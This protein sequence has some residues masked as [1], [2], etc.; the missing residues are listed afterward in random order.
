MRWVDLALPAD[1]PDVAQIGWW[2]IPGSDTK[3]REPHRVPLTAAAIALFARNAGERG[4]S[5]RVRI[6][7]SRRCDESGS[8]E[9][10]TSGDRA[11]GIDFRGHDLGARR[12]RRW[13]SRAFKEH[14]SLVLNHV[15]GG[16]R[17]TRVYDRY[18][19]DSGSG[20]R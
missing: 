16:P 7:R 19:Y 12:R 4:R 8:R 11:L 14:I 15:E 3:N 13:R 10:G 18:S 1:A 17:A 20:S 5:G 9:E 2:T 6:R